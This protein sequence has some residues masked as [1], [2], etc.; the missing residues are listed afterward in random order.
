MSDWTFKPPTFQS[1]PEWEYTFGPEVAALCSQIGY[2]PDPEQAWLLDAV[3][4]VHADGQA[5]AYETADIAPRQ[6]QK[7][8]LAK[9]CALGWLFVTGEQVITWSAHEFATALGAFNDLSAMCLGSPTLRKRLA[10]D[11][12]HGI[13]GA[14]G[15][16]SIEL[17]NGD[18]LRFRA[19][20]KDGSRG[21]T[22]D[23]IILDEAFALADEHMGAM[24]PTLTAVPD[25]QILYLSSAGKVTSGV[26]RS[27]R[28][29]GRAGLDPRLAYGEWCADKKPCYRQFEGRWIQ[30]LDCQHARPGEPGWHEGCALDDEELWAQANTLLGRQRENGTGLTLTKMRNFRRSEPPREWMRE[31]MGW[32]EDPGAAATFG[33]GNWDACEGV[34]EPGEVLVAVGVAVSID[35]AHSAIVG[36][37]GSRD[38]PKVRVLQ[39]GPGTDW[40][41]GR[42]DGLRHDF[43]DVMVVI[44]PKGPGGS[45]LRDIEIHDRDSTD[46][47]RPTTPSTDDL[48]DGCADLYKAVVE[49]R[50][51][52]ED[53]PELTAA[54]E[55]VVKRPVRDRWMWGRSQSSVDISPLEAAT[56][57]VWGLAEE[58]P[59]SAYEHGG[60]VMTI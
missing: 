5:A 4:A 8:G 59:E 35:L 2:A 24:L 7:T 53:D 34:I 52:H 51:I 41:L 23:K 13:H 10:H 12:V 47:I 43:R 33:T 50:L 42:L 19:R 21:L 40:V 9:M 48:L 26:L 27:V 58:P 17:A 14:R 3:F 31:R 45:L 46:Q 11:R 15:S 30:D 29:R 57:A 1:L 39:S 20:T 25:P 60:A 55:G 16:E 54:A 18:E 32:W 37:T 44:D 49:R 36:A 28:N 6:N 56:L 38:H 22:G